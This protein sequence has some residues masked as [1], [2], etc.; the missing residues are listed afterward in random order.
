MKYFHVQLDW[1]QSEQDEVLVMAES[2]EDAVKKAWA[3]WPDKN[4]GPAHIYCY[5]ELTPFPKDAPWSRIQEAQSDEP[6]TVE[7]I[8]AFLAKS[9]NKWS[10]DRG[11]SLTTITWETLLKDIQPLTHRHGFTIDWSKA[12]QFSLGF[13]GRFTGY[14]ESHLRLDEGEF[15]IPRPPKPKLMHTRTREEL[16]D[17]V[18]ADA[19]G[20]IG[21]EGLAKRLASGETPEKIAESYGIPLE[22]SAV[23]GLHTIMEGVAL[24]DKHSPPDKAKLWDKLKAEFEF[25]ASPRYEYH[26]VTREH[27]GVA[28]EE[29]AFKARWALDQ[30]LQME[31]LEALK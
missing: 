26:A 22:V 25:M 19:L 10:M 5:H 31:T 13:L 14:P 12:G 29:N 1:S 18:N 7:E 16:L 6:M 11:E 24:A 3:R 4:T 2:K 8:R 28:Y 30:M 17:A 9:E 20:G 23:S 21:W 27:G 15:Y